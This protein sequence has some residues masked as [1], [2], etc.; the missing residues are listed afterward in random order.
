MAR[1]PVLSFT[2]RGVYCPAGDFYIDPW[3]PVARAMITHGHSDHARP[4][5]GAYLAT[6]QSGPVLR[7]RLGEITF[8][9]G[10]KG[11]IEAAL[12]LRTTR[13]GVPGPPAV[14]GRSRTPV[15]SGASRQFGDSRP[16][17]QVSFEF[18]PPNG[19]GMEETLWASVRRLEA[20]SPRFVSVTYGADGSTR[21]RTHDLVVGLARTTAMTPGM[22]SRKCSTPQKQPPAK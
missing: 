10:R 4:G 11:R 20:L 21:E 9:N 3:R 5:H 1:D 17:H 7:H 19:P 16:P 15:P 13:A 2:D 14:C 22:A 6:H 12:S 18:F 8:E